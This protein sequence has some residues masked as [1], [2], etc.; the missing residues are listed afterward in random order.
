MEDLEYTRRQ[1][2]YHLAEEAER[3]EKEKMKDFKLRLQIREQS[4]ELRE[5]RA[6]LQAAY[7]TKELMAQKA[8]REAARLREKVRNSTNYLF[9]ELLIIY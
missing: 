9:N 5:L 2:E 6:H 3:I 7:V 8:E 4:I 1:Q